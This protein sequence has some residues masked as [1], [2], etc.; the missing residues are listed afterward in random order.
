MA[1]WVNE[2]NISFIRGKPKKGMVNG[3]VSNRRKK[4]T[5]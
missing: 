3:Y 2:R 4:T 5:Q 1:R